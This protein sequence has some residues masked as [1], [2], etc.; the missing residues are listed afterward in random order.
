MGGISLAPGD[1][2][3]EGD[4]ATVTYDVLF[5]GNPAYEG[6]TGTIELVDGT[7][8]V[9]RDEFCSFMSSARTPCP[10]A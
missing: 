10:A 6:Q 7:W 5:G 1:V 9:S 4:T 8:V 3:V 2:V